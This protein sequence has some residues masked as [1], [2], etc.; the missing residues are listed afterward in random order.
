MEQVLLR[1]MVPEDAAKLA[2][3]ANNKKTWDNVRDHFPSPTHFSMLKILSKL[4]W[5]R[6]PLPILR[7][8]T[9]TNLWESLA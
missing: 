5:K 7:S 2:E 6:N 1:N 4:N 3:L 9:G 8:A